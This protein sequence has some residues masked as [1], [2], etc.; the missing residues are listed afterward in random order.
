MSL[1]EGL[2][3]K[4]R[5]EACDVKV[6]EGCNKE[7]AD[8]SFIHAIF[9][10]TLDLP[11]VCPCGAILVIHPGYEHFFLFICIY[12]VGFLKLYLSQQPCLCS[13]LPH[14]GRREV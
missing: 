6:C 5:L 4:R 13:L 8:V 9:G 11:L 14:G 12:I 3:G 2:V 7:G 10:T 1:Q